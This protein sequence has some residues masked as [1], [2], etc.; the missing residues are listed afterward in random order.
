MFGIGASVIGSIRLSENNVSA[1][2]QIMTQA[3]ASGAIIFAV[4]I[5]VS[6]LFSREVLFALGCSESLES[7]ATDYLLWL[8]PGLVFF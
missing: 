7:L 5:A 6:L 8:L 3:F 4:V 2:R 1:A